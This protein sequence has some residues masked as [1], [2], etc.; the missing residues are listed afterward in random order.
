MGRRGTLVGRLAR[1]LRHHLL[2]V[3][4]VLGVVAFT[5]GLVGTYREFRADPQTFSWA[6]VVFFTATLFIAD[7]TIFQNLGHYPLSLE[8]ARF[9][10][11]IA[12][13]VGVADAVSTVF[14]QRFERFR[15]RRARRHV[16]VCGTGPTASALVDKLSR[17]KQVVLVAEDAQR[18][19][20]D[21]ELPPGLLRVVGDPVEPLVLAQAGVA[22]AE[23]IYGCLPD[24]SSNLGI[25][26]AARRLAVDRAESPLRCLAQVGDL[27][28]I[29]HL[30]ARRIGLTDDPGFR[31]DFFAIEVL[32]AHALLQRHPPAW[33]SPERTGPPT[34]PAAPLV[35]IGLSGLG[36]ALVTEL[37]RRWQ[38]AVGAD[39]PLLPLAVSGPDATEAVTTMRE[40]E[41]AL[42]R[43]RLTAHDTRR[44]ALPP[45]VTDPPG[46]QPPPEFVY[47]C[48]GDEELALL[49]GLD[50]AQ[51]LDRRFGVARTTIVVRTG[52]Q[53]SLHDVFGGSASRRPPAVAG[54]LLANLRDGVRF[55]AVNDEALPLDLG[56]TDFVDRLAQA[57][58]AHYVEAELRAGIE[59]GSRQA[60]VPWAD[61]PDDLRDANRAQ[62]AHVGEILRAQALMLMPVDAAET[63][64]AFTEAEVE[65]LALLE[66]D[67]WRRERSTRG[68]QLGPV[69]QDGID[70]RHPALVDWSA[71]AEADQERARRAVRV[72]PTILAHAGLRIVRLN[73]PT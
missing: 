22:R 58:H 28:L 14:A 1:W 64:F 37:A 23:V 10:A 33:A 63:D 3:F 41:P 36:R 73:D 6:N 9:L 31:L 62:A 8:I 52:R 48:D 44:G 15:A 65:E 69:R 51:A 55:F 59:M 47:V 26:L 20:P 11:P 17:A 57:S 25:A 43:V 49:A 50:A 72:L 24:T 53:R 12:T 54:P 42:G 21:A 39:G 16:V 18:E 56:D 46:D 32:G 66:H 61:L 70:R 71:L 35:V 7:G 19:Y 2:G 30:R 27:S 38:A 29:P 60:M 13:T 5:L 67:R 34:S 4:A 68:Y 40:R 45:A